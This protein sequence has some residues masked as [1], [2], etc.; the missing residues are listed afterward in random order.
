[1]NTLSGNG[2]VRLAAK[3]PHCTKAAP[4]DFLLSSSCRAASAGPN[5]TALGVDFERWTESP[6]APSKAT[7]T[8]TTDSTKPAPKKTEPPPTNKN[9][10]PPKLNF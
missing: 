2:D 10:K 6:K 7:S 5:L 9:A 1:M 8:P 4:R 3:L